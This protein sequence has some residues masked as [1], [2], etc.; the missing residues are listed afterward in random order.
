MSSALF[1]LPR[2]SAKSPDFYVSERS[3]PVPKMQV[4]ACNVFREIMGDDTSTLA[5][6]VTEIIPHDC[7]FVE[8]EEKFSLGEIEKH[9][10]V[11]EYR[12]VS[13]PSNRCDE[14]APLSKLLEHLGETC[15][16]EVTTV[17]G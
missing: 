2:G 15:S 3:L 1:Y 8:C 17:I 4:Q 6:A 14:K 12:I 5:V 10:K 11:C 9:E 7:K 16:N 13:C